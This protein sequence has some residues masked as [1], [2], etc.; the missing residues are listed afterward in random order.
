MPKKTTCDKIDYATLA[1]AKSAIAAMVRERAGVVYL[2]AYK[3]ARCK[4]FHITSTP[5][6]RGRRIQR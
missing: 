6:R 5:P 1:D 2:K 4:A 3:C